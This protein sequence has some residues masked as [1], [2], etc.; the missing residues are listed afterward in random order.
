MAISWDI[1]ITNVN[2]QS[3]RG[4]VTATRTDD[5]SALAPQT[6]RFQATPLGTPADRALL[7]D[8]IKSKVV[9]DATK[10]AQ[11]D[12]FIATL[13]QDG[14]AALEAWEATR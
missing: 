11:V 10:K 8:S 6:Y 1:D 7:L 5:Q 4:D 12:A 9:E 2:L 13:E 14:K 3:Q